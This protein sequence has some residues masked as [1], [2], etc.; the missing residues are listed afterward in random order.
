MRS[1]KF[2]Q[3][4]VLLILSFVVL[5]PS[6][7]KAYKHS[8]TLSVPVYV[9]TDR[10][11]ASPATSNDASSLNVCLHAGIVH[12]AV[13]IG[14]AHQLDLTS[15]QAWGCITQD[16]QSAEALSRQN[17]EMQLSKP[18]GSRVTLKPGALDSQTA[19]DDF[20]AHLN[21]DI[22]KSNHHELL[23]YVHGCCEGQQ[24]AIAKAAALSVHCDSPVL[25]FDWAT[26]SVEQAGIWS[27]IQSDRALELSEL[28][29]GR[30]IE[31]LREKISRDQTTLIAFSMGTRL[32]R[33]YL[34]QFPNSFIDEVQL[35]RP[36]I[37]LPVFLMEQDRFK[38]QVG[39]MYIYLSAHDF[40]LQSSEFLTSAHVERLGRQHD[41]S[42][43]FSQQLNNA[44]VNT[45]VIDTTNMGRSSDAT[46]LTLNLV[47]GALWNCVSIL[48]HGIPYNAI[49]F[50]HSLKT[51]EPISSFKI[52]KPYSS[53]P[54]FWRLRPLD[55][56]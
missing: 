37:S 5:P 38:N 18:P 50:I 15:L 56:K 40:A 31:Q 28:Y 10:N 17:I 9:I 1:I 25:L 8:Y 13:K 29:F 4:M 46:E 52:D 51:K 2:Y 55:Y 7:A 36:D 11:F 12:A 19:L 42:R 3:L 30:L 20:I 34:R 32:V 47:P 41:P 44:P 49:G 24:E 16:A 14:T 35:V 33:N 53:N 27:Y 23:I 39:T 45:I 54:N 26:P 48:G 43:W 6:S 21:T 22:A